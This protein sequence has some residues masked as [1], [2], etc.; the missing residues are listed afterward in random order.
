MEGVRIISSQTI[1][2]I[3][4]LRYNP[5]KKS[6]IPPLGWRDFIFKNEKAKS[7]DFVEASII[8]VIQEKIEDSSKTK[9]SV[10][11]S[12]GVDSTLVFALLKQALQNVK[13]KA[14]SIKFAES[15]DE[16]KHAAKIAH[17]FDVDH[18]V[19]YLENYLRDL[20]K[21]ISIIKLPFWDLHWYYVVKKAKTVSKF[22]VSGDGGDEI[23]GGYTFRY[24]KFLSLID[25]TSTPVEKVKA[26][27][28]CHERDWVPDQENLFGKKTKFNWNKVYRRMIPFF[29]NSLPPLSQVFL[30]DFN[31]KLLYNW[32]PL[33]TKFHE[34][35]KVKP[36]TPI[37]SKKLI[38]YGTHLPVESKYDAQKNIGKLPL[39]K[40]LQKYKLEQ[41]VNKQKQGFSV[42]T[43]NLWKSHGYELCDYYLSDARIVKDKWINGEWISLHKK[44]DL[45][46]RYVNKFLG[47]LALEIWYRLFITKEMKPEKH[48]C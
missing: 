29:S 37:L 11:L 33:N 13:I 7:D 2:N 1:S 12:G 10:S 41:L 32:V 47:I 6:R 42:N 46:I 35:F 31:G 39:R 24:Q 36:I 30:A 22:L 4:T 38:A 28:Q 44:K 18:D 21:A 19:L 34:H 43:V 14:T 16:S 20:P 5:V 25:N 17:K 40:I 23:F 45:D 48:L 3:L 9:V 27:L 26:Y 8:K 15:T